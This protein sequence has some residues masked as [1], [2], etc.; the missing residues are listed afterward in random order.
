VC[1]VEKLSRSPSDWRQL[2]FPPPN[3]G[4]LATPNG[5]K[6]WETV[7]VWQPSG[8]PQTVGVWQ[9]YGCYLFPRTK[10]AVAQMKQLKCGK[11]REAIFQKEHIGD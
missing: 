4:R 8:S 7:G 2:E 10:A 1:F 6:R 5:G 9:P 3:G 11:A